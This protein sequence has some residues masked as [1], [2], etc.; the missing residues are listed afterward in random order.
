P[1]NCA[2]VDIFLSTDGGYSYP[3]LLAGNVTNDGAAT[4]AVPNISTI[5]ARIKVK[6]SNNVFFDI[7]NS[8]FTIVPGVAVD[9]DMSLV[10]IDQPS[11]IICATEIEPEITIQNMGEETITS[12]EII[13][14]IDGGSN[15]MLN[16]SGTLSSLETVSVPLPI[17]ALGSGEYTLNVAL[18]NPNSE[19][20]ENDLNNAG[21]STFEILDVSGLS[22]PVTNDFE[23]SFPGVGWSVEDPDGI[24]TWEQEGVNN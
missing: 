3:F 13:Y 17:I 22:L 24:Y 21:S 16:W 15:E 7:S 6:A 18:Q 19:T 12:L 2:A 10:S 14:N 11:G 5:N 8:D 23:S 4:V 20:D 9:Y 1:V